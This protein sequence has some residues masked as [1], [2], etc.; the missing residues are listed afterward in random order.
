M[1]PTAPRTRSSGGQGRE[2]SVDPGLRDLRVEGGQHL[3]GAGRVQRHPA[4]PPTEESDARQRVQSLEE[5]HVG[6]VGDRQ[7]GGVAGA[8]PELFEQGQ[9]DV[10]Q[11]RPVLDQLA[12][13]PEVEAQPVVPGVGDPLDD[14]ACTQRGQQAVGG[15]LGDAQP[16]GDLGDAQLVGGLEAVEQVQGRK[17]RLQLGRRS[18]VTGCRGG[19]GGHGRH[20]AMV[21]AP[22]PHPP[23]TNGPSGPRTPTRQGP[24]A[25][26]GPGLSLG[27]SAPP[28][29][30]SR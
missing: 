29:P 28:R 19:G 5:D 21:L 30:R 17:H 25:P 15:A 4:P 3:A 8:E 27:R 12:E 9:R 23:G 11:G 1:R 18:S 13:L 20:A 22:D 7:V 10:P 26:P 14:A 6:S 16:S 24:T 2:A